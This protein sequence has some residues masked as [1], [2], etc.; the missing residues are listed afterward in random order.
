MAEFFRSI[1][2]LFLSWW[3]TVLLGA[4]DSSMFFFMPFGID[5]LVIIL[6]ARDGQL[7]WLYPLL[8]TA[9]SVAGA[10]VT[11]WIGHKA[12][13]VGL[14][15]IVAKPRL[16][17]IRRRVNCNGATPTVALALPAIMPPP[18]PLTPFLLSCGA[19]NVN[20]WRF[21]SIFAAMRLVRFGAE[22]TLATI[23]GQGILRVFESAAFQN[24]VAGFIVVAV[25]GTS[26]TIFILWKNT[27]PARVAA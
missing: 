22:A 10:A 9:G 19:L 8:A 20:P 17:R 3:G 5:A 4:L 1:F 7:F 26:V 27:R 14:E 25:I 23:Y 24:V 6:A 21:F 11:Y 13:E 16:D 18:F 15:R 12:G 2:G